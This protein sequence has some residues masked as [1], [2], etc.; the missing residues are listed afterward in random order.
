MHFLANPAC[1]GL[2][3]FD[4]IICKEVER[5]VDHFGLFGEKV[6]SMTLEDLNVDAPPCNRPWVATWIVS[7]KFDDDASK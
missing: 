4:A 2:R 5:L 7:K 6:I 1:L 3:I